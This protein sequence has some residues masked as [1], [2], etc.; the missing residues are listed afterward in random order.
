MGPGDSCT[1]SCPAPLAGR[2][3]GAPPSSHNSVL[4]SSAFWI[5]FRWFESFRRAVLVLVSG[6]LMKK[7][8]GP[9]AL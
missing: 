4:Y 8:D 9:F 1:C 2:G 6:G 7:F 3:S 5:V